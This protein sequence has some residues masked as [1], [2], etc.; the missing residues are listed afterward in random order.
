MTL[1][2]Q[3][4]RRRHAYGRI[5]L[6]VSALIVLPTFV[7]PWVAVVPVAPDPS[8]DG[9]DSSR[10]YLNLVPLTVVLLGIAVLG[11]VVGTVLAGARRPGPWV[12]LVLVGVLASGSWTMSSPFLKCWGSARYAIDF[13]DSI[14]CR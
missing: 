13:E 6:T 3:P 12:A 10:L 4:E 2:E 9:I 14:S 7:A 8:A 1:F 11:A 5:L